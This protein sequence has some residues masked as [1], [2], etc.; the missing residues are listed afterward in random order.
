MACKRCEDIHTAQRDGKTQEQCKCNC[1]NQ[2]VGGTSWVTNDFAGGATL[3]DCT[4]MTSNTINFTTAFPTQ[5]CNC[6]GFGHQPTCVIGIKEAN[7]NAKS[8][9]EK[10]TCDYMKGGHDKNCK[11]FD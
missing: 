5:T 10:C 11:V 3:C 1:H 6:Q 7:D 2:G 9:N 8:S 4:D